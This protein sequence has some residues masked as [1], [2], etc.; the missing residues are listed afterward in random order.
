MSD[1]QTIAEA[2]NVRLSI[3]QDEIISL[4]AI[5]DA[6]NAEINRLSQIG[7]KAAD[8]VLSAIDDDSIDNENTIQII[9]SVAQGV[10][11]PVLDREVQAAIDEANA[12][13][14]RLTGVPGQVVKLV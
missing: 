5:I 12:K 7:I 14:N 11:K 3:A 13:I 6:K 4:K 1:F 9:K 2:L 8:D 10:K